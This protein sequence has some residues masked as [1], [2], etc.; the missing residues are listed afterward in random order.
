MAG[1]PKKDFN[2]FCDLSNYQVQLSQGDNKKFYLY[3]IE[4]QLQLSVICFIAMKSDERA[5]WFKLIKQITN[6][7][8][9][10]NNGT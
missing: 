6:D 1:N 7:N 4:D 9:S 8:I 3:P 10:T 2:W 5:R